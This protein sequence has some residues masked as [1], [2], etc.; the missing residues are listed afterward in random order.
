MIELKKKLVEY[1]GFTYYNCREEDCI[2]YPGGFSKQELIDR[3]FDDISFD[4]VTLSNDNIK[5]VIYNIT[6]LRRGMFT[7]FFNKIKKFCKDNDVKYIEC[8][9][10][11]CLYNRRAG[12]RHFNLFIHYGFTRIANSCYILKLQ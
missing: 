6:T 12:Y 11:A 1:L 2:Q 7:D 3:D 9:R 8:T 10:N 4:F 5:L